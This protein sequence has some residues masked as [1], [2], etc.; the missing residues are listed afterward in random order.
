MSGLSISY[1]PIQHAIDE[2]SSE[3]ISKHQVMT[4]LLECGRSG[5]LKFYC[6]FVEATIVEG[7]YEGYL[8]WFIGSTIAH[9]LRHHACKDNCDERIVIRAES[10]TH[11]KSEPIPMEFNIPHPCH[12]DDEFEVYCAYY[13]SSDKNKTFLKHK[14]DYEFKRTN[15]YAQFIIKKPV[16]PNHS[17]TVNRVVLIRNI[18]KY[19]SKSAPLLI[20]EEDI[21]KL[22][23]LCLDGH[24]DEG[25]RISFLPSK[26]PKFKCLA[27]TGNFELGINNLLLEKEEFDSFKKRSNPHLENGSLVNMAEYPDHIKKVIVGI[28]RVH[29]KFWKDL[30][31]NSRRPV[32]GEIMD[33]LK[34]ELKFD[35]ALA[36][37]TDEIARPPSY[38]RG[39]NLK[40]VK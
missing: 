1:I 32:K 23:A 26:S 21:A 19:E 14:T 11:D 37:K 2:L 34:K 15:G 13:G 31:K 8:P 4:E 24:E 33:W 10:Y 17:I 40:Y 35:S 39:G 29:D 3:Q 28:T 20:R 12:K 5:Q 18:K 27:F 30:K 9:H 38:R 16:P 6:F 36:K 7:V 22:Y 25:I